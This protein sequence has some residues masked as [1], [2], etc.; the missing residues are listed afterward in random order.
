MGMMKATQ[1]FWENEIDG[2]QTTNQILRQISDGFRQFN[3]HDMYNVHSVN[4]GLRF[5]KPENCTFPVAPKE[6]H[7]SHPGND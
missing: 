7:N 4:F 3:I 2:N 6:S 1:Y 5:S